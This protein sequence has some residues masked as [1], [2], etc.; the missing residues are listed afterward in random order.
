M[1]TPVWDVLVFAVL[2]LWVLA[3]FADYLCHRA[4]HI[5]HANGVKES[6][7]HWLMLGEVGVPLLLAV[8]FR[9]DALLMVIMVV[10]LL[11]HEITSNIDI[12]LATR[13]RHVSTLEQQ[14]H[15]LLEMLPFTAMLLVFVLHWPQLLALLGQGGEAADWT[16]T[17]KPMPSLAELGVPAIA[18]ALFVIFPYAE[19]FTRGWLAERRGA[20]RRTDSLLAP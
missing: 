14:V 11:A 19:E 9:I 18:F 8:F 3:G 1:L 10:A 20:A 12:R 5:E 13:T 16:L 2:P 6:L 15:S 4:T 17:L 7:I